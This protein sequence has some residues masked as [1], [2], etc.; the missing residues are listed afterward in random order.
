MRSPEDFIELTA[1]LQK[2]F[3]DRDNSYTLCV[4][5]GEIE[6]ALLRFLHRVDRPLRMREIAKMYEI[7]NAKVTRI[8]D[9]LVQMGFVERYYSENDRR[10][11][12]ARITDEG[13]KMA[14]NTK[15]KLNKFQQE[16]LEIIP[17]GEIEQTFNYLKLFVDAYDKIIT[18]SSDN[19]CRSI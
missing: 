8:L 10:C 14:E 6:C 12:F 16:V 15:Y 17:E 3:N 5:I 4:V 9:K 13:I 18:D 7:S 2:L 11:W 1:R 19:T